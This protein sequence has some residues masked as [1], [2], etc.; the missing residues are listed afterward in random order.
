M[1]CHL[2]I[3]EVGN[4]DLGAAAKIDNERYLSLTGIVTRLDLYE[5]RFLPDVRTF[6]NNIFGDR[7]GPN[8]V[9]HRREIMRREG[10][11]AMLRDE[12]L[13]QRFDV[14]LLRLFQALPYLVY[15][16]V[17]DKREHLDT[18]GVWRFDPYHYCLHVLIERYVL[19]MKRHK[20]VGDVTAEPRSSK[21]D[22]RLKDSYRGIYLNG[23][24]HISP[25]IIQEHL[26]SR[27][28]KFTPKIA[29][30]PAMQICDLLAYPSYKN[31]RNEKLGQ[32]QQADFG[33]LVV[34]IL[35]K[36]K[37]ARHPKTRQ[38]WGV[39]KKWLPK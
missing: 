20:Y 19:W 23:T 2:F 10:P 34:N 13:K 38:I 22:R 30:C 4:G 21:A 37:N 36:W 28:L 16:V 29:N 35:E 17:I 15:T 14:D 1:R 27:E 12:H 32:H 9:L 24:D 33:K 31:I 11:F 3:D 26:T 18:Y 39:G 6:K 5:E 25:Q 7:I 8:I